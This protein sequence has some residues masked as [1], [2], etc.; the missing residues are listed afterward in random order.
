V[1]A[2][3]TGVM[4][5]EAV[6]GRFVGRVRELAALGDMLTRASSGEPVLVLIG[7]EAGVGKTRLAAQLA[8]HAAGRGVRVLRGG[9]VPLGEEGLPFAPVS[10][11]LRGLASQLTPDELAAVAGPA[12]QELSR[13]FHDPAAGGQEI[14]VGGDAV[15]GRGRLFELLL[16]MVERLSA[17]VPLLLVMEDLHWA[18]RSTRDLVTFLASYLSA[19]R[20]MVALTFRSD[21][22][23]GLHPLRGLLAEL[24]RNRRVSRLELP[25]FTRPELAEQLTGLLGEEPPGR[26][27]E[28]VYVRSE[29]N[30][31][32]AEELAAAER[33]GAGVLPPSLQ[34]VLLA[35]M[36]RLSRGAQQ[37]LRAAAAAGPGVTQPVLAAV[38]GLADA[39]LLD[40]LREAADHQ[41]LLPEPGGDGYV[42]RHA[43]LAE[44]LYGNLLPGERVSLHTA[45]AA[46]LE[47]DQGAG[48]PSAARA[49]RLAHHWSA[50]GDHPRALAAS[51]AAADAA[52]QAYA[53]AEA[54]LQLERILALWDRVPDAGQRTGTDRVTVLSRCANAADWAGDVARAGQLV[55]QAVALTDEARE[56]QR[57]AL[58]RERLGC[59]LQTLG[60][61][62]WLA[63]LG[64]AVRLI[65][66]EPSSQRAQVVG[67]LAWHLV[68]G[69]CYAEAKAVAEEA[70]AVAAQAGDPAGEASARRALGV[71][72]THLGE[73][74]TGIAE[75]DAAHR[76]AAQAGDTF[77]MVWVIIHRSDTLL[78]AGRPDESAEAALEGLQEASRSGLTRTFGPP[79]AA[80]ATAALTAAGRW[81]QAD[82]VSQEI[83]DTCLAN[84]ETACLFIQRGILELD[85]G[86]LDA[87]ET[88]LRTARHVL[89]DSQQSRDA[90][91]LFAGLA[92]LAL[93]REDLEQARKLV[94]EAMPLVTA[95]PRRAAPLY[96]LGVRIEADRAELFRARQPRG[97]VTDDGTAASLLESS[98]RA[99]ADPA[100]AGLP[101]LAAWH[102]TALGEIT[103]R[104]GQADPAA[105]SAAAAAWERLGQPLR[106]AYACYR[107]AEA[108]MAVGGDR[109]ATAITLRRAGTITTRLGARLLDAE[110]TALAQRARLDITPQPA[111]AASRAPAAPFGLTTR[112][113]EVLALVAAGRSNRQIAQALFI[114][115]KT[116]SVHVSNILAK[117][118]VAGRV[119]AAA[120]AH[121]LGLDQDRTS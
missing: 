104:D 16:D 50:A 78:A 46:I 32:F 9:C 88:Q 102:A 18:D 6:T 62:G 113:A 26:L 107:Q 1:A 108:L 90:G 38:T 23:P 117:L 44:A 59:H 13:L 109:E 53:F 20:V 17:E 29:G 83:L 66:P 70:A 114:S 47:A 10:E 54:G 61:P 112:E 33:A 19:G 105:W 111:A 14:P 37:V 87:A 42:F 101:E 80:R 84:T 99:S 24:A 79:L 89:P 73:T 116:A 81:D 121:R 22:L 74:D 91:P 34:E 92:E 72:L 4:P 95:D 15:F 48:E 12:H 69:A 60:D 39:E 86:D 64:E 58:L 11:A 41:V 2:R 43:L 3:H 57:L 75:L 110:V 100:A 82:R 56:P 71:S 27:V 55:R 97:P 120:V 21:E 85:R 67:S 93:W 63:E 35:R 94:A 68:L 7:G 49:A 77:A 30:P 5:S 96:A 76:L 115:P 106:I 65:G 40:A 31:F 52:E 45:L 8:A 103:R 119:E 98:R 36:V 51:L 118:G 25:P 28:D